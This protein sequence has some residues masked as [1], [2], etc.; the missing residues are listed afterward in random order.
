MPLPES[1][2]SRLKA[3]LAKKAIANIANMQESKTVYPTSDTTIQEVVSDII[4]SESRVEHGSR[5]AQTNSLPVTDATSTN[6][7]DINKSD[8]SS[9]DKSGK[10]IHLNTE[11]LAAVSKSSNGESIVLIGAAGTGKTTSTKRLISELIKSGKAGILTATKHKT[12]LD[13]TPG[14][15]CVSYTRRAVANIRRNMD[16]EMQGNCLT[17]HKLLEYEP[18]YDTVIDP[19]SGDE[20]TKMSFIPT[21]NAHNP[22]PASIH[23]IILDESSMI[24]LEL[25]HE[26]VAAC[27]HNPQFIFLGDIQ[28]LPPV[29]G[30]AILGFK[31]LELPTIELTKVYRQAL[32][33]PII[34][35]AHRILSGNP[36]PPEE[37]SEWKVPQQLTLH[38]WKKKLHPDIAVTV[39]GKFITG[40]IDA[41][42]Y[43]PEDDIILCPFNKSFGTDEINKIVANYIARS[44]ARET[45]EIIAGFNKYYFSIGDKVLVDKED[46]IITEITSNGDY[47]GAKYQPAS[48]TLDYW[49]CEQ[50]VPHTSHSDSDY[51][52]DFLLDQAASLD[53]EDR[54]KQCSHKLKVK[55]QDSDRIVEVKTAS[56]V[57]SMILGYSLTV[58]KAQGSEWRKVF[59]ALHD[60]HA[61][62]LQR[63]LLY[64]A[65]TR[66]KEELYVI[67]HPDAFVK[68]IT[69]QR[70]K[71]NTLAEKCKY[72]MG[73]VEA[74][75]LNQFSKDI[76]IP[77][78]L[79]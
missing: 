51:D 33:S 13:N 16:P 27:P 12:L 29:F 75:Y 14:I 73:K 65:V 7:S 76:L 53:D 77:T 45:H 24:S 66:A 18:V 58:H 54:V 48:K 36:I 35:L 21:R 62:M 37:F 47:S 30:S 31:M 17:I 70:I 74:G 6:N 38:P 28:Q 42:L 79:T 15:V 55:M 34:R 8:D 60:S 78:E 22:L 2:I 59:L 72:F 5:H 1:Q 4:T 41:N 3:M 19:I 67:C 10:S 57:N 20:R 63:E 71:G 56:D 43:I 40:A 11:Q 49:G 64:T 44:R 50:G 46:G 52:V 32:E 25:Y 69:G 39:F 26:I 68:G 23:T 61:T 9:T